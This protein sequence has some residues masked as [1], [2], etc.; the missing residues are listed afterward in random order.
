MKCPK[1]ETEN[2]ETSRFCADCGTQ[3]IPTDSAAPEGKPPD[4]QE[5]RKPADIQAG[6]TM[7][8]EAPIEELTTGSIFADR[9]KIVTELGRGGMGKVY[10]AIDQKIDEE[11][12]LKLIKPEIAADKQTIERFG[13]ELKLARKIAHRNVCKM[14]Y[15]GEEKGAH[16]ITMEYVPGEDLKS[17]IRMSGQLS[18]GMAIKVAKQVCDGLSEAHRLGVIHRDLKPNNIMIDKAGEARIMDFGIARLLKAKGIT[19]AGIMIGTPEYMSPEQVEG[20]EVD[21][22]SDIYSLGVILYE[23][24][25]GKVPFEGDTPFTIGMKH[26]GEV[27]QDPKK[28]NAHI[29]D[30]LNS[31]ILKCLKKEKD[32]R[33]QSAGEVRSGL[34]KI[35]QGLPTTERIVAKK[36]STTSREITVKFSLDRHFKWG[37]IFAAIVLA[38]VIIWQ[39]LPKKAAVSGPKIENSIAVISFENQTGDKGYDYLQKAI[40]N[41]LISDLEQTGRLYVATWERMHDILVQMGQKDVDVIDTTRGF[42]ICRR[43]GIESIVTG[44]FVKAGDTFVTDVKVLDVETKKMLKSATSRGTGEN[45]ILDIQIDE[46]GR[47]IS[48]GLGLARQELEASQRPIAEITTSSLEA[49]KYYLQGKE[50]IQNISPLKAQPSLEK[51][52]ELDPEFAMAHL[53]LGEAYYEIGNWDAAQEAYKKAKLYSEKATEKERFHIE[54]IYAQEVERDTNKRFRLLQEWVAKYPKEKDAYYEFGFYYR[55]RRRY[56]DAIAEFQKALQLDPNMGAAWNLLA[57][58]YANMGEYEKALEGFE[59][60]ADAKPGVPNPVDSMAELYF[61]MGE[62]DEAIKK[63]NEALDIDPNFGCESRLAYIYA[64]K[65]DYA[66]AKRLIARYVE[67][68]PAAG[69]KAE[70]YIWS[71]VFEFLLGKIESAFDDLN[72]AEEWADKAGSEP[73][74]AAVNYTRGWM[75]YELGDLDLSAEHLQK[76]ADVLLDIDPDSKNWQIWHHFCLG[77]V[78]VKQGKIDVAKAKL[79]EIESIQAQR[80]ASESATRTNMRQDWLQ[81]EIL[82]TEGSL[83]RAIEIFKGIVY[84]PIPTLRTDPVLIYNMPFLQDTLARAYRENGQLDAAIAE[85]E[86]KVTFD[87]QSEDRRLI[88]PKY[89]YLLAK[90]YEEK[91][92]AAKAIEHYE[93]FLELWKDADPG[94]PEPHDARKRLA[95]L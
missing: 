91:G 32:Q 23:M 62:L 67:R 12:A 29:P 65:Q 57:Y 28:L 14:Y 1:C 54:T 5:S 42:E 77:L 30:D 92:D 73:R 86:R 10:R 26:K 13:N 85:Y 19:G 66:E 47:E 33:Y 34:E 39:L 46:L 55:G 21:Q 94:L 84:P 41:L 60:Y 50:E 22:R 2:P 51:A 40:P 25:T 43:E 18:T 4:S 87:P 17:M 7:T 48:L 11:I 35:E 8:I 27:P 56:E 68:A 90:L 70:A 61:T 64:L 93:M 53:Y 95:G 37:L 82:M 49:Y 38:G 71:S 59:R 69:I 20:K 44:S 76:W 88:H 83:D 31:L 58:T 89:R 75:F 9:Y 15:L 79:D 45:S 16:Y 74:K 3:L 36:K 52:V 63:Y 72:R 6:P 24:V 78:C 80:D 81:A